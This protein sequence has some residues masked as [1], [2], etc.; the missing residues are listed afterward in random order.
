[1]SELAINTGVETG[2]DDINWKCFEDRSE[3]PTISALVK[4]F[5]NIYIIKNNIKSVYDDN[6][7]FKDYL[8]QFNIVSDNKYKFKFTII[9]IKEDKEDAKIKKN[10]KKI[11][12]KKADLIIEKNKEND[13]KKKLNDFVNT[14]GVTKEDMPIYNIKN[15]ESFFS[16]II[17]A[18]NLKYQYKKYQKEPYS[19]KKI[20]IS[21]YINCANSLF[22][23]IKD[24]EYFLT[25]IIVN[26]SFSLLTNIE[27]IISSMRNVNSLYDILND[28]LL[29][30]IESYWDKIKPKSVQLYKEQK[31]IIEL[32]SSTLNQK[33][34][35]FYEMPPANGKTVNSVFLSKSI[36]ETNK[37]NL[38]M[39]KNYKRKT[40]LYICYNSIVRNEVGKLCNTPN[41][42]VKFWLAVTKADKYDAKVKT[43]LRPFRNCY[44]DWKQKNMRSIK[45][46]AK[47]KSTKWKKFSENIHDQME[48]FM[49]DTR[50]ICE[51]NNDLDDYLNAENLPE[52]IISDLESAY[53]LLKEFPETFITYF[54]EAFASAS[55][56]ITAKIMSV[57]G[58]TILVSAT[59]AK[60]EEIPTVIENFKNKHGYNDYSFLNVIKSNKQHISCT[61]VN[62]EGNIIT[63]HDKV[64]DIES[65][66]H[67]IPSLEV[68]LI[69]RAYSP[70]VLFNISK[71]IEADL[72]SNLM[73]RNKFPF[74]GMLNHESI[75]DYACEIL[76]YIAETKNDTLFNKLKEIKI[77]KISDM[78][79]NK[80]FTNSAIH[81][82]NGNTLHVSISDGFDSHVENISNTFLDGSSK[83]KNILVNY[84]KKLNAIQSEINS[85]DKNG[86]KDS[87]FEKMQLYQELSNVK[88]EW[89]NIHVMN[90]AAH[91]NRFNNKLLLKNE[92]MMVNPSKDELEE[93]DETRAKLLFSNIGVYQPESFNGSEMNFFMNRKDNFR[94]I[95]STPEIVYGTNIGL[96]IIDIDAKFVQYCTKNILYQV[97]GRAGRKGKSH[98]AMIIF[99]DD[100]MLDIILE[101]SDKNIEAEQIEENIKKLI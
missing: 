87:E 72:P 77:N 46:D 44:P 79:I 99:R 57:M 66:V 7:E 95:L 11:E 54:D 52:M 15:I 53:V 14:L 94:F 17:W 75:R 47:Y 93:L 9:D 92:N 65:L 18:L 31:D 12:K 23:A 22:R 64:K 20:D 49:N 34:L 69:R 10:K 28:N 3:D 50:R 70:E 16:I 61:F 84:E 48:F 74:I 97:I 40:L 30:I 51:Q 60:P 88:L 76:T 98:S 91:A 80:I 78:D 39:D 58:Y 24:S 37:I 5:N 8:E 89:S 83:I 45:E 13:K 35:F 25:E 56:E 68:P 32:V 36:K 21:I 29:V 43:F 38:N 55:E 33:K 41:I 2:G 90:T 101:Q 85:L 42:D 62:S 73:F 67:F 59:L 19:S 6:I 63:P 27:N 86:N 82:Q 26:E 71:N 1:M 96:S 81:Y 100:K 4:D